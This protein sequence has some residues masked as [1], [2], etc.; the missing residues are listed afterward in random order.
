MTEFGWQ[1][2]YL[3]LC[4][5]SPSTKNRTWSQET[6][7]LKKDTWGNAVTFGVSLFDQIE[8]SVPFH[9]WQSLELRKLKHSIV[10]LQRTGNVEN[11][12]DTCIKLLSLQEMLTQIYTKASEGYKLC[13]NFKDDYPRSTGNPYTI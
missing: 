8:E 2:V 1:K 3:E 12:R 9:K 10:L 13:L 6:I 7:L 5:E 4:C 11:A